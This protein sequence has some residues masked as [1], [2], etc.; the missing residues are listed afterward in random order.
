MGYKGIAAVF[1]GINTLLLVVLIV[2]GVNYEN[3]KKTDAGQEEQTEETAGVPVE[4]KTEVSELTLSDVATEVRDEVDDK[5]EYS[6]EDYLLL[7]T[8]VAGD[9]LIRIM[10]H[11]GTPASGNHWQATV[12]DES[13]RDAVYYDDDMDGSIYLSE[14]KPGKYEVAVGGVGRSSINIR[15]MIRFTAVNDIRKIVVDESSIDASKEDTA[16]NEEARA[17]EDGPSNTEYDLSGGTIGIDVSKYQKDIDWKKVRAAGVEY[18]II[19]AGYRGSSTGVLVKDP[20]FDRNIVGAKEA[21]IKLGIY[22]FSQAVNTDEAVEEAMAAASLIG[23]DELTLPV[24]LDV[25]SSGSVNG[26][27]DGLDVAARTEIIRTFCETLNSMGYK[28]GVYANKTWLTNKIDTS[29][30]ED[31]DIWLAQY[32]MTAPDYQGRYSI[33]QYTSKGTVD[34][35]TGYVD[36]DLVM[37]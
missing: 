15:N 31:Y 28:A 19:R 22:F 1:I 20:Y 14:L 26:R 16:V 29:K 21:G 10:D 35:I 13:G 24:Y 2:A 9:M 23:A 25:E 36:M 33:W 11:T 37:N 3:R 17:E 30:L 6:S 18:A 34:G 27:A 32:R 4:Y 7:L 12:E 8:S 5:D